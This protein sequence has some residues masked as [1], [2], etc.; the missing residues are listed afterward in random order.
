MGETTVL[1]S[2]IPRSETQF[3][4]ILVKAHRAR[5]QSGDGAWAAAQ[6][7]TIEDIRAGR[8]EG[9]TLS[10]CPACRKKGLKTLTL[11]VGGHRKCGTCG[12]EEV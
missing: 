12:W 7:Q 2:V 10:L 5:G 1:R 11:D 3:R 8:I 9:G 4:R 6:E